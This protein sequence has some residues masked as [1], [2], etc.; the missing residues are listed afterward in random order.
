MRAAGGDSAYVGV[1]GDHS[2]GLDVDGCGFVTAT[3][4]GEFT[5]A[6]AGLEF[7]QGDDEFDVGSFT[8]DGACVST[9]E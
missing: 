6:D 7:G 8:T 1:A 9:G 4:G 2:R 3:A 5:C